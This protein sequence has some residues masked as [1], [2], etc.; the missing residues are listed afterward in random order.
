MIL[1]KA[2]PATTWTAQAGEC[3]FLN[4]P[5]R[6][7]DGKPA[8][9]ALVEFIPPTGAFDITGNWTGQIE[10]GVIALLG[11]G[12]EFDGADIS[13]LGVSSTL[14]GFS[15][16]SDLRA[17]RLVDGTLALIFRPDWDLYPFAID[18]L[19]IQCSAAS[20]TF[21]VGQI[22]IAETEDWCITR[23]W[24]EGRVINSRLNT[25]PNGQ[26]SRVPRLSAREASVSIAPVKDVAAYGAGRTLQ[27]LQF[28]LDKYRPVLCIPA[29]RGIGRGE[30]APIDEDFVYNTA[31]FGYATNL[32][33]LQVVQNSNLVQLAGLT[34]REA[35]ARAG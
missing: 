28:D 33:R 17:R 30:T 6:L 31:L 20:A 34:F 27:A 8:R 25:T 4:D 1:T 14:G 18:G 11:L 23:D 22:H 19:R 3:L 29:P 5:A 13:M 12:D 7:T 21:E 9:R 15:F 35:P 16:A 2:M 32:G 10:P 24:T 26:P